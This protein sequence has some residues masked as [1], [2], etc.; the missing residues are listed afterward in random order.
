MVERTKKSND[1][2][3]TYTQM[4]ADDFKS[5]LQVVFGNWGAQAAFARGTG[6]SPSTIGRYIAGTLPVPQ[7]IALLVEML[8]T[9]RHHELPLPDS[10][11]I[12]LQDVQK[13]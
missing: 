13:K 6:L 11:S 8:Q 7:H 4:S 3:K 12:E 1:G 2:T 10:F 9:L 5:I